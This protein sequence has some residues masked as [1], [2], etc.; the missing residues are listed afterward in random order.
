MLRSSTGRIVWRWPSRFCDVFFLQ[1]FSSTFS[2]TRLPLH[3]LLSNLYSPSW[4][5][6]HFTSWLTEWSRWSGFCEQHYSRCQLFWW[7]NLI[8]CFFRFS[9]ECGVVDSNFEYAK[10]RNAG[11]HSVSYIRMHVCEWLILRYSTMK[12]PAFFR[13][14]EFAIQLGGY[15][16]AG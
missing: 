9:F 14:G 3:I 13:S 10:L 16:R 12:R 5:H 8:V 2:A 4:P 11:P 15:E 7:F 1:S 6:R